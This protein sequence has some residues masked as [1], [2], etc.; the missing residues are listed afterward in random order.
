MYVACFRTPPPQG[1]PVDLPPPICALNQLFPR[2]RNTHYT[3]MTGS[4]NGGINAASLGDT[5][6]Y[7]YSVSNNGTTTMSDLTLE[8]STVSF[9]WSRYI[10]KYLLFGVTWTF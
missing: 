6:T 7:K 4:Y 5:I 3:E 10:L 1:K 8:D 9:P 2:E